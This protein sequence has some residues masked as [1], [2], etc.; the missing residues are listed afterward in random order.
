MLKN[1]RRNL[2]VFTEINRV[3]CL[4]EEHKEKPGFTG[5]PGGEGD[6]S[7]R[8]MKENRNE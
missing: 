4:S 3:L 5:D 1:D 8:W 2:A 7:I 6:G